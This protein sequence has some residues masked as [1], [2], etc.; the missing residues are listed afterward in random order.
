[1]HALIKS[2]VGQ[3]RVKIGRRK[4]KE[5]DFRTQKAKKSLKEKQKTKGDENHSSFFSFFFLFFCVCV[6]GNPSLFPSVTV[7]LTGRVLLTPA[8]KW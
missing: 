6:C 3:K 5:R 2:T 1:M 8:L 4:K 7:L